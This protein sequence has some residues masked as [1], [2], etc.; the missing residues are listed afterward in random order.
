[1]LLSAGAGDPAGVSDLAASVLNVPVEEKIGLLERNNVR[2]RVQK[3][4]EIVTREFELQE[5]SS[6]IQSQVADEVGKTQRQYYLREQMKAI[7]KELG[8]DDD[9]QQEIEEFRKKIKAAGRPESATKAAGNGLNG[10]RKSAP[11]ASAEPSSRT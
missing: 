2:D 3:L 8:E 4:V 11:Q 6:R 7:Q 10:R 5:I 1:M 9:R